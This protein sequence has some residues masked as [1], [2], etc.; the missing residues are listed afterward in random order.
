MGYY[1]PTASPCLHSG[2][3]AEETAG[4]LLDETS[5]A[6]D[7]HAVIK[8]TPKKEQI[9]ADR[10]SSYGSFCNRLGL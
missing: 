3:V 4:S 2:H 5:R 8:A 9:Q 7:D 6:P 10:T 1:G